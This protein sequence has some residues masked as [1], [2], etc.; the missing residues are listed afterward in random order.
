MS[1]GQRPPTGNVIIL[2]KPFLGGWLDSKGH[3]GHEII[4]FFKTDPPNSEYYV[5]NNPWGACPDDIYCIADEKPLKKEKYC[6][7]YMVLT[8]PTKKQKDELLHSFDILYVIELEQKLHRHHAIK[9]KI[10][11]E[12]DEDGEEILVDKTDWTPLRTSQADIK[13]KIENKWKIKYNGIF[14]HEIYGEDESLYITFKANKIYKAE[15]PIRVALEY[16]FQRNKGYIYDTKTIKVNG[17]E[18]RDYGAD[19]VKL[20]EVINKSIENGQLYEYIPKILNE[21]NVK[22]YEE[23][24]TFL[25]LIGVVDN[26]QV[27]TNM[28][29]SLLE[30]GDL[31]KHFCKKFKTEWEIDKK[32]EIQFDSD[33]TFKVFRETK[34]VDG[35]MDVCAESSKQR[36]IIENKVHSGLN[37]IKPE[38]NPTQ[39]STYYYNWGKCDGKLP[40]LCFITAP[41]F[42]C[43]EIEYEIKQSD[44]DMA[45]YYRIISYGRIAEFL[46]YELDN[47]Y[48]AKDYIYFE[49][50]PQIIQAFSNLAYDNK[51]DMYA[52]MFLAATQ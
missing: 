29:H 49:L 4:N 41:D 12:V 32:A 10:I 14:L 27:Y 16:N 23:R 15:Q 3:I 13:E 52:R 44:Q 33:G 31:L 9:R 19:Y 37:G 51:E 26:E 43:R 8:G 22:N 50:V 42:R 21:Q 47:G 5:Y 6:A 46:Q 40:P 18:P 11:K 25:D 28:L 36:V 7:K 48:I 35:R 30:H 24:K 17:K 20:E 1:R 45:E 39:L 38:D 34:I 2:N